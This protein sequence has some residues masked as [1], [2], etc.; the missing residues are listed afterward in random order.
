MYEYSE[1]PANDPRPTEG[2]SA[3][4]LEK[5]GPWQ[6]ENG[7][8]G[9]Y[10]LNA[11]L[12]NVAREYLG[13]VHGLKEE[14]AKEKMGKRMDGMFRDPADRLEEPRYQLNL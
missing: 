8:N 12:L 10:G 11:S 1:R 3:D 7:V 4:E 9:S 6:S 14:D 2:V 5:R 13:D